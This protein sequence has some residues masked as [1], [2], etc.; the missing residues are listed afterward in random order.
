MP[1]EQF[2]L[3]ASLKRIYIFCLQWA[4]PFFRLSQPLPP[5]VLPLSSLP[6]L[7]LEEMKRRRKERDSLPWG[8]LARQRS[9]LQSYPSYCIWHWMGLRSRGGGFVVYSS[10]SLFVCI[11]FLPVSPSCISPLALRSM[12]YAS[13]AVERPRTERSDRRRTW[14]IRL[15]DGIH[16]NEAWVALQNG[17]VLSES[18]GWTHQPPTSL[19]I[20]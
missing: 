4:S 15:P 20:R 19:A 5:V 6:V 10:S 3:S 9:R 2:M 1:L 13:P 17:C 16:R 18:P 11:F 12:K 8:A 14:T 7:S